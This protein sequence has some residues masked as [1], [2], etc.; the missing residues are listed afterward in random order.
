MIT[1]LPWP[2]ALMS[3]LISSLTHPCG[4]QEGV[5]ALTEDAPAN[6]VDIDTTKPMKLEVFEVANP[7]MVSSKT[8]E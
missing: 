1:I 4:S 5:T 8:E 7:G 6:E 2:Q 3:A